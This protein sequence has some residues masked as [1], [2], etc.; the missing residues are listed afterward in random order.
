LCGKR[1][2]CLWEGQEGLAFAIHR[3]KNYRRLPRDLA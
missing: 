3:Y 2:H 1:G